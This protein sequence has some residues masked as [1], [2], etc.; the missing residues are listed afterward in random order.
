MMNGVQGPVLAL[1]IWSYHLTLQGFI[2]MDL[3]ALGVLCLSASLHLE[4]TNNHRAL[5]IMSISL[6]QVGWLIS[7]PL[8]H[9]AVVIS[10]AVFKNNSPSIRSVSATYWDSNACLLLRKTEN[11]SVSIQVNC[12]QKVQENMLFLLCEVVIFLCRERLQY[13]ITFM[14]D[15]SRLCCKL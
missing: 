13:T 9:N 1:M 11:P 4:S 12:S 2:D 10:L 14:I 15:I 5:Q 8:P 7:F 3:Q 6:N